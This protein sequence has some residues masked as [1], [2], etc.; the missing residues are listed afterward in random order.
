MD[1]F[2]IV[3]IQKVLG[4]IQFIDSKKSCSHISPK[5]IF[6]RTGSWQR[7]DTLSTS[8]WYFRL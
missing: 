5:S 3:K 8:C 7:V 4:F 1:Y 2:R 6:Y